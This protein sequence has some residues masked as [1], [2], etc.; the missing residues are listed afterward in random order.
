MMFIK[1]KILFNEQEA[2]FKRARRN[3]LARKS[4]LLC[5]QIT[6]TGN[7][8]YARVLQRKA[9]R[10]LFPNLPDENIL[11]LRWSSSV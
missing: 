5:V 4:F 11:L 6:I 10:S 9:A 2:L 3:Y 7:G 1:D 8:V